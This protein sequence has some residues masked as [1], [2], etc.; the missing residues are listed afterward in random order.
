[1][2]RRLGHYN[3]LFLVHRR[4]IWHR[5]LG[6]RAGKTR[7]LL[8]GRPYSMPLALAVYCTSWTFFGASFGVR[9]RFPIL[10]RFILDLS[11]RSR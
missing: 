1:M 7:P 4:A 6:D 2:N 10:S 9:K 3:L 5:L 11:Q 8:V